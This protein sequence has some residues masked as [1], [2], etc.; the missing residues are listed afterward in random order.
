MNFLDNFEDRVEIVCQGGCGK[1]V[2]SQ[3]DTFKKYDF[4][5]CDNIE[6]TL[7]LIERITEKYRVK[8]PE[9]FMNIDEGVVKK[10]D[11][12]D[13]FKFEGHRKIYGI[14]GEQ[15]FSLQNSPFTYILKKR[16]KKLL[17]QMDD[18]FILEFIH[19]KIIPD[20]VHANVAAGLDENESLEVLV[21]EVGMDDEDHLQATKSGRFDHYEF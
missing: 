13:F 19:S 14:F 10:F 17:S 9:K 7:R 3:I 11:G 5:V 6:C 2:Y 1:K 8:D 4:Y 15:K 20:I 21:L 12:V 18:S 16:E